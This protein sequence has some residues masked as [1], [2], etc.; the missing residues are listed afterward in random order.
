MPKVLL[1][2]CESFWS[3]VGTVS[4]WE[5]VLSRRPGNSSSVNLSKRRLVGYLC[6]ERRWMPRCKGDLLVI[7]TLL[8]HTS[9]TL[10][11]FLDLSAFSPCSPGGSRSFDAV[12]PK[13][14]LWWH[15]RIYRLYYISQM[16]ER[17][18]FFCNIPFCL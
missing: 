15:I 11:P 10:N 12:F 18:E 14:E 9:H 7:P 17:S 13:V 8:K 1:T 16:L 3:K 4:C 5:L 2:H 6:R